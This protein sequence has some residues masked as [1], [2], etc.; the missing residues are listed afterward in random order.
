[1][2]EPSEIVDG[3]EAMGQCCFGLL[4][5]LMLPE[6]TGET[7][8][9]LGRKYRLASVFAPSPYVRLYAVAP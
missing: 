9:R 8:A 6:T 4:A 1:M 2:G 3:P 5:S 7:F